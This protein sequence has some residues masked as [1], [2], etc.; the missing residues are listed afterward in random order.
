VIDGAAGVIDGAA[1]VIDGAAGVIEGERD[2]RIARRFGKEAAQPLDGSARS[3]PYWRTVGTAVRMTDR[4]YGR[5][6]PRVGVPN[7][8]GDTGATATSRGVWSRSGT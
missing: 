5:S 1:G 8:R 6:F 2:G 3:G 4:G 7:N